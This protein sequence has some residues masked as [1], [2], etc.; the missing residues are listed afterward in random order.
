MFGDSI[1]TGGAGRAGDRQGSSLRVARYAAGISQQR[2]FGTTLTSGTCGRLAARH[3]TV[4]TGREVQS[5]EEAVTIYQFNLLRPKTTENGHE[6]V[7][8]WAGAGFS[9]FRAR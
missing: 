7:H 1:R 4:L 3:G 6:A 2:D 9:P 5:C 8:R